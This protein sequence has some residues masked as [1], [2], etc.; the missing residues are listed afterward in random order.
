M[1][2]RSEGNDYLVQLVGASNDD[3]LYEAIEFERYVGRKRPLQLGAAAGDRI[4][5]ITATGN[6][7]PGDQPPG[8]IGGDS[9]AR[10]IRG[11]VDED[12][13]KAIVLR[14][15]SGGGSYFASEIVRQQ[16]LYA[17]EKDKPLIVSMGAIAASGGYYIAADATEIWA[18]PQLSP[19][20][21]VSSLLSQHLRACCSEWAYI[22]TVLAPRNWP[23]PCDQIAR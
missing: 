17:R 21:S 6:I 1:L 8:A 18:T 2:G 11:A 3:G 4:G 14:V 9:L 5:V 16:I 23:V 12:D 10:L 13:I 20:V 19:A 15:N 7:L 22:P